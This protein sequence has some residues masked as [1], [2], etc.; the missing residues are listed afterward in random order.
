MSASS[1][2]MSP[3]PNS[4]RSAVGLLAASGRMIREKDS[5]RELSFQFHQGAGVGF[6]HAPQRRKILKSKTIIFHNIT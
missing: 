3:S 2:N 5:P 6:G 1:K 4:A